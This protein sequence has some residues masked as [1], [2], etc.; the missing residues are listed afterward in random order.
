MKNHRDNKAL[1]ELARRETE[2]R[3]ARLQTQRQFLVKGIWLYFLLLIFEGALR[4]WILPSLANPLLIVRDPVAI[5]LMIYAWYYNVF[6]RT[7]LIV[8][9]IILTVISMITTLFIGHGNIF[10]TLYGARS[11]IVHFPFIFL[12]G[13]I[14][15]K[16]DVLKIGKSVL[17]ISIPMT[18]LIIL[19]F[20]SPQSAWINAGVGG[21][22]NGGFGGAM[23]YFRPPATFSFTSGTVLFF[24]L[25]AA[26]IL[27]FW[28]KP[29]QVNKLILIGATIGLILALPFSISRSLTFTVAVMM[30]FVLMTLSQNPKIMG[31]III[32]VVGV[33]LLIFVLSQT[34][35]LA[36]P[37]EV[38]ISRFDSAGKS[39]GGVEGTLGNRYLGGLYNSIIN[40]TDWPFFG[41]G[42]GMGTNAGSVMLGA[43]ERTFLIAEG[44]WQRILG[45]MGALLG[46]GVIAIRVGLPAKL[47]LASY[48]KISRGEVLPWM[49]LSFALL[50]FPQGN[51]AQPTT[52]GFST[53]I[54]GLL[55]ASFNEPPEPKV[56]SMG[57]TEKENKIPV[58]A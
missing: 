22:M 5:V 58:P 52:L 30:L 53:L 37:M 4:K 31:K 34:G 10:V 55:I 44:E 15:N 48:S 26:Y 45:E 39:E 32:G 49:L 33:G 8:W 47:A 11:L 25:A 12:I 23:G 36:K 35:I 3:I 24:S 41:K 57:I 16:D 20:Y 13:S 9:M 28:L 54:M 51:W 17:W 6:P 18:G 46:L 40:S 7:G 38:F 50:V 21:D 27:Y 29:G 2:K 14:L 42:L 1:A 43:G 56:D 19:Q